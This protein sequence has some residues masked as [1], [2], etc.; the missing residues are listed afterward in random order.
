[1]IVKVLD[2]AAPHVP[3]GRRHEIVHFREVP[4]RATELGWVINERIPYLH[5]CHVLDGFMQFAEYLGCEQRIMNWDI[6]VSEADKSFARQLIDST[7]SQS[8]SRG[9]IPSSAAYSSAWTGRLD[10]QTGR[11]TKLL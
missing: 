5:D 8:S 6:P 3:A 1:M 9:L 11:N 10:R 4:E 7:Q 2:P